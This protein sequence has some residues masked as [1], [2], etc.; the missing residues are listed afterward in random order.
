MTAEVQNGFADLELKGK[1][2]KV[3]EEDVVDPWNVVS[4]SDT[5][6]DYD[7]LISELCCL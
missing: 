1:N 2:Q 7:K 6:V 5:G 4:N 3:E